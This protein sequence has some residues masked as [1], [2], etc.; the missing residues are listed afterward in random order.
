MGAECIVAMKAYNFTKCFLGVNGI[1]TSAGYST[2]DVE[3]ARVKTI[4]I[5][6]SRRAYILAD[7]SKFDKITSVTFARLERAA[8]LTDE[9]EDAKYSNYTIVK[10]VL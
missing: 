10:E 4:V 6:K 2:P 3:E 7:H 5:E 9:L 8:I 1:S